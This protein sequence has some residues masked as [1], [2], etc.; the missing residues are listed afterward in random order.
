MT[1][2]NDVFTFSIIAIGDANK[3]GSA[4]IADASYIVNAIFFGG[5]QPDPEELADTNCDG[6]MNIT[7]A[8][9]LI[10]YIFFGGG[11]PGCE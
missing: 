10:N 11:A 4:N 1:T 2:C 3:D 7:D 6:S 8:S 5:A 9:Y